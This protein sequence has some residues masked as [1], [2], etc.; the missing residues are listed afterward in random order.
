MVSRP[1]GFEPASTGTSVIAKGWIKRRLL[2]PLEAL[3]KTV[4]GQA[5][6]DEIKAFLVEN[7]AV[8]TAL[9]TRVLQLESRVRLLTVLG[10]ALVLAEV[11]GWIFR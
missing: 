3:V 5:G 8:H 6:H 1:L 11:L 10:A 7:E 9:V 2:Q 4:S